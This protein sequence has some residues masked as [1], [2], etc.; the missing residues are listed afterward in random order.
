MSRL[1]PLALVTALCFCPTAFA[2][3]PAAAPRPV[4]PQQVHQAVERSL[5]YL[6]AESTSWLNVR[7]CAACHH[8]ALPLW[9]MIEAER[10][11]YSVDKKFVTE[12]AD[13][14]LGSREKMIASRILPDP[15]GKPDTRPGSNMGLCS[16]RLQG[17]R[18]PRCRRGKSKA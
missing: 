12:T 5:K 17:M 11:G 9:S 15:K 1:S 6:Q 7:K 18:C 10:Q 16:W 2:D 3:K 13:R 4:T 8:V 14:T